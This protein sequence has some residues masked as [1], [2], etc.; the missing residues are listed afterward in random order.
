M[1]RDDNNNDDDHVNGEG[2]L[3]VAR[4]STLCRSLIFFSNS[5][6]VSIL[7]L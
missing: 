6:G 5:I 1:G 7:L 4:P 3:P 2:P